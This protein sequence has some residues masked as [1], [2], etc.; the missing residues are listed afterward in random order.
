MWCT[1]YCMGFEIDMIGKLL[2]DTSGQGVVQK[3][4]SGDEIGRKGD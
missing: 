1:V 3:R 2:G 4:E